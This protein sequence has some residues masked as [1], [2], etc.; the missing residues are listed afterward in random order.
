LIFDPN[1]WMTA[2]YTEV[3]LFCEAEVSDA[4]S[5]HQESVDAVGVISSEVDYLEEPFC[6]GIIIRSDHC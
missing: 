4:A 5:R 1:D 6:P 2:I 3:L